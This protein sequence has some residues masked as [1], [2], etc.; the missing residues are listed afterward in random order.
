MNASILKVKNLTITFPNTDSPS[1][2]DLSFDL[3]KGEILGI[4]GESG[5]GK[6]ATALAILRLLPKNTDIKGQ[7]LFFN[8]FN[9]NPTPCNLLHLKEKE[10]CSVRGKN[11][12]IIFQDPMTFLN[13]SMRCGKQVEEVLQIHSSYSPSERKLRVLSLFK[14]LFLPDPEKTYQRYPHQLSGGQRQRVVMAIALASNPQILIADEPTTAL[15]VTTQQEILTLLKNLQKKHNLSIIFISHDLNLVQQIATR[16]IVLRKG[17]LIEEGNN[18]D[19]FQNPQKNYTI[20][21]LKCR[22]PLKGRPDTLPVIE[23]DFINNEYSLPYLK[24]KPNYT[25]PAILQVKN[26]T[27]WFEGRSHLSYKK[28]TIIQ[29]MSFNLWENETLGIVGESGSGK[30][31]LGRTLM[32]LIHTFSGEINFDGVNVKEL[33][34]HEKNKFYRRIQLIFQ[35]PYASLNPRISIGEQIREPMIVHQLNG[36]ENKQKA[37]V[38]ELLQ[39]V[40]IDPAWYHRYPHQLSG[41]QRQRV[42]IA[43][44]LALQPKIIICDESVSALDVSIAAQILNLLNELKNIYHL[45][46]LFISHDMRIVRYMSDRILVLKDGKIIEENDADALFEN[47]THEYTRRL[48]EASA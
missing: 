14:E 25:Q 44:A 31:T 28:S 39:I 8:S 11:I 3:N 20:A 29:S 46:Y 43:R 32:Q 21:L 35:D 17:K 47:P 5:S 30:T 27:T 22:P 4:V 45:S 15:D 19:I 36:D 38:K 16:V 18:P 34:A 12:S 6:S 2:V 26:L 37:K 42:V 41:G 24:K 23:D 40:H 7:I 10:L 48:I 1:V 33:L 13:P 9:N